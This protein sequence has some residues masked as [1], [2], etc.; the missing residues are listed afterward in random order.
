MERKYRFLIVYHDKKL[1][2]WNWSVSNKQ[3]KEK[4]KG[5]YEKYDEKRKNENKIEPDKQDLKELDKIEAQ[6]KLK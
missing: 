1:L 3:M 4:V 6:L 2:S 5:I